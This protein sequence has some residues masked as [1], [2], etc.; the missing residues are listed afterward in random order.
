M[1]IE[2]T[3]AGRYIEKRK[4]EGKLLPNKKYDDGDNTA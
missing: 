1:N 4:S 3:Q 2:L